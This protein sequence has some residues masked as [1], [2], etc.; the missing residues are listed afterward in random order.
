MGSP[1]QAGLGNKVGKGGKA[2]MTTVCET[3][4]VAQPPE[5]GTWYDM[6]YVPG[7]LVEGVITPAPLID[8]PRGLE[9]KEPPETPTITG[10][11]FPTKSIQKGDPGYVISEIE[12]GLTDT[13]ILAVALG[14]GGVPKTV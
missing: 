8:K 11:T 1:S 5:A 9:E 13:V 10:L 2:L 6:V 14:Q 3:K 12:G 4:Y 7:V